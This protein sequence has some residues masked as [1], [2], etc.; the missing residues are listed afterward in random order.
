MSQVIEASL[1]AQKLQ[2]DAVAFRHVVRDVTKHLPSIDL[3]ITHRHLDIEKL[4]VLAAL[5]ERPGPGPRVSGAIQRNCLGVDWTLDQN[6]LELEPYDL[7]G[8]VAKPA[9]QG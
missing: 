2:F 3:Q 1:I 8:T 6:V 7:L 5:P 4:P 9:T